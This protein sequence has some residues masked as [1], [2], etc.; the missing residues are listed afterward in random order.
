MDQ[1]PRVL[2]CLA[3]TDWVS[4]I[5]AVLVVDYHI[6]RRLSVERPQWIWITCRVSFV[7]SPRH[8]TQYTAF[9]GWNG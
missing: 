6:Y 9:A 3:V 4:P 7:T 2:I 5:I 8:D 1:M